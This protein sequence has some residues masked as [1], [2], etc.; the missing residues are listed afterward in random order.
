MELLLSKVI[1]DFSF[2]KRTRLRALSI[3]RRYR[4]FKIGFKAG[5]FN[6]F[7]MQFPIV[8]YSIGSLLA[9]VAALVNLYSIRQTILKYSIHLTK[10]KNVALL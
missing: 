1:T 4:S 10:S 7:N 3:Y 6:Y 9:S 2:Q 8:R 5:F